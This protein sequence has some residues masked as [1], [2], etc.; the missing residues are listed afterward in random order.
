MRE[1]SGIFHSWAVMSLPDSLDV[2][3]KGT[4]PLG[5]E[6]QIHHKRYNFIKWQH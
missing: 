5:P 6:I 1:T 4:Y 2:L 3:E